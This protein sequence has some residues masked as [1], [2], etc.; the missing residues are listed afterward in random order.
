MTATTVDGVAVIHSEPAEALISKPDKPVFF[1]QIVKLLL[2]DGREVF[3]CVHCD[4]TRPN[5]VAVR[6]HLKVHSNGS[7]PAKRKGRAKG[8]PA[9]MSLSDLLAQVNNLESV[10]AE[11]DE[12]RRRA[13]DAERKLNAMRRALKP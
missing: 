5:L 2:E 6:P 3:G 1:K 12:W 8:V 11:R 7:S 9:D 10:T 4:F 13:L